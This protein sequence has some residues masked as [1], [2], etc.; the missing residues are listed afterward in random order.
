[1]RFGYTLVYH[2]P[3]KTVPETLAPEVILKARLGPKQCVTKYGRSPGG[4]SHKIVNFDNVCVIE[5]SS[6]YFTFRYN[7]IFH[8]Q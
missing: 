4:D 1:M 7:N 2:N 8:V 5:I 3:L 6:L